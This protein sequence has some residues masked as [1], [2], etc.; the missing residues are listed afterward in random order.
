[1][2][3]TAALSI[4]FLSLLLTALLVNSKFG[5]TGKEQSLLKPS[6]DIRLLV[7]SGNDIITLTR[8][9]YIT[10]CVFAQMPANY[11]PEAIKAQAIAANTY[12]EKLM[13]LKQPKDSTT[14]S[15]NDDIANDNDTYDI[16]DDP[17][18]A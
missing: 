13:S 18:T 9:E 15:D 16:S 4:L 14:T 6:S 10:G 7:T 17:S 3:H 2:K 1:M 11:E 8:V 5:N 12:A